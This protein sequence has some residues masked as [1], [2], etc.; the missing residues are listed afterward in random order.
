MRSL[1]FIGRRLA[2]VS[3]IAVVTLFMSIAGLTFST[4]SLGAVTPHLSE[5]PT[6]AVNDIGNTL[7]VAASPIGLHF[8]YTN[9]QPSTLESI[10]FT[11]VLSGKTYGWGVQ[12]PA[13]GSECILLTQGDPINETGAPA[14]SAC[15]A[16]VLLPKDDEYVGIATLGSL[17]VQFDLFVGSL[18]P[19]P[20]LPPTPSIGITSPIVGMAVTPSGNGYWEVGSDGN[21]Y[22]EGDAVNYGSMAGTKLNQ[23][24]VGMAVTPSGNGYWLVAADGG[25]FNFGD[26]M[27]YGSTGNFHLNN[28][29]VGMTST[30]DGLGYYLVASDGGVFSFGDAIFQGSMGATHLNQPVVGMALDN[31]T[32]GYWLVA[33]DGGVFSFNANF[34]GSTGAI[35]LSQ[36]IVGMEA[37]PNGNG[38]RLVA[39]DGGIF[40]FILQF[41][42]SMGGTPLNK[43][44]VGMAA[45]GSSG[46][47]LV[48]SDG[49]VFSF[50]GADF[51]GTPIS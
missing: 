33:A 15:I 43:P 13:S 49:G 18:D 22:P 20:P 29:I 5:N 17:R 27:F 35:I 11:G 7:S 12:M 44:V 16:N 14:Q 6:T 34:Y 46:Y 23:P 28:S 31:A 3:L 51:F 40:S 24:I 9:E 50:G 4:S 39:S 42:G 10:A 37:A 26:A 30:P 2:R 38:Y 32:G 48:A 25:I 47:W 21:V 1:M 41:S 8:T 36:P 19:P 45:E